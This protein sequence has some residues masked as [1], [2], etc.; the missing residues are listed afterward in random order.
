MDREQEQRDEINAY[1]READAR[2]DYLEAQARAQDTGS[3]M[4]DLSR[5]RERRERLRQKLTDAGERGKGAWQDFREGVETEWRDF[6]RAIEDVNRRYSEWD[7][8]RER[9]FNARLDEAQAL[10]RQSSARDAEVFAAARGAA[11]SATQ[12]LRRKTEDARS[13]Y[14]AWKDRRTDERLQERL[15]DAEMELVVACEQVESAT[16]D[17]ESREAVWSKDREPGGGNGPGGKRTSG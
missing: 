3:E 4:E 2:L 13:A 10:L 12:N 9:R 15:N 6:R 5:L 14:D 8:A 11:G 17:A 1:I 7:A 16:R